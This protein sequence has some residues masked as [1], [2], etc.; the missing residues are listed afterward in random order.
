MVGLVARRKNLLEEVAKE[1]EKEGV[2]AEVLPAD[3]RVPEQVK[4]TVDSLIEKYGTVDVLVNNAGIVIKYA[5]LEDFSLEEWNSMIDTN[6]RAPFLFMKYVLPFM[7]E[8]RE[9]IIV[10]VSSQAGKIPIPQMAVYC[11]TKYGLNGLTRSVAEEAYKYGIVVSLISPGM[12]DTAI[13]PLLPDEEMKKKIMT[14][15]DVAEVVDFV[16]RHPESVKVL[17]VD[18]V[19]RFNG[20]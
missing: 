13:H 17:D 3:I 2:K 7:K 16:V 12:I 18:I 1:V 6:L 5:D 10:N 14:P 11:A 9:G 20:F 4:S 15:R 19:G 8:R